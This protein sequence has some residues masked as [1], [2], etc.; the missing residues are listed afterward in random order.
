MGGIEYMASSAMPKRKCVLCR[1][2]KYADNF[3]TIAKEIQGI[4]NFDICKS[5]LNQLKI[6]LEVEKYYRR[7]YV[8][9]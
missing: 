8:N 4:Q 1:K 3:V 6:M 7:Y 9:E 5:C 2:K